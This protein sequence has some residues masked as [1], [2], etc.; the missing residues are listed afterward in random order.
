MGKAMKK[1]AL[2]AL[3][4]VGLVV[5]LGLALDLRNSAFGQRVAPYA[6]PEGSDLIVV[7]AAAGD[8]TQILTVIDPRTQAM[9]VYHVDLQTGKIA[10]R[11]VRTLRWDLQMTYMNNENPLPQEIR[12]LLEQR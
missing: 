10:L 12:G 6:S 9:G 3:A 8:K 11:S 2:G 7:P 5:A 4:A 1:L